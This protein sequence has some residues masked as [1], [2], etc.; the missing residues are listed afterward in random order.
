MYDSLPL[1]FFNL[2][3]TLYL[4]RNKALTI[5]LADDVLVRL[6]G[7]KVKPPPTDCHFAVHT[8]G[9]GVWPERLYV[10]HPTWCVLKTKVV[11]VWWIPPSMNTICFPLYEGTENDEEFQG[12]HPVII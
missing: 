9:L 5:L 11:A 7:R 8:N 12:P 1:F 2:S 4:S 10:I 6:R 3:R